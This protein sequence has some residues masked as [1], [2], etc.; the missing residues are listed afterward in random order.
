MRILRWILNSYLLLMQYLRA[1]QRLMRT[2]CFK[3]LK[4][5]REEVR[6]VRCIFFCT[7]ELHVYVLARRTAEGRVEH[8]GFN[9]MKP[10]SSSFREWLEANLTSSYI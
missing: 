6:H 5:E 2:A 3:D 7:P 4:S 9:F 1:G 10:L 8:F